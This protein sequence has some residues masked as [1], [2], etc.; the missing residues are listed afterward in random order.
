MGSKSSLS[1]IVIAAMATG[2][3]GMSSKQLA[4]VLHTVRDGMREAI[5]ALSCDYFCNC[6]VLSVSNCYNHDVH[7]RAAAKVGMKRKRSIVC[8][9]LVSTQNL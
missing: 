3:D 7:I 6:N 9:W 5:S 8:L 4:G 1:F 2:G